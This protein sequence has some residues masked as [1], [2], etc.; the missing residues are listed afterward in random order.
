MN[1][2]IK[3]IADAGVEAKERLVLSVLREDDIGNYVVFDTTLTGQGQVSNR[4][5]HSYW[6]P[7]KKVRSGDLVVLYTKTGTSSE[8]QNTDGSTTHFFYM[9][10]DR[11]VWNTDGDCAVLLHVDNW[12][13]QGRTK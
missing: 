4:M 9:N 8:K 1:V 12:K 10:I 6:F 2:E 5:R 11:T 7:D 13:V 3:Y